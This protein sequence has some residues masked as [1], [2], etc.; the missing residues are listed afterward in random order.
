M[1]QTQIDDFLSSLSPS[2][3]ERFKN[4]HALMEAGKSKDPFLL[5]QEEME[6]LNPAI[7]FPHINTDDFVLSVP[8]RKNGF[9]WKKW[10]DREKEKDHEDLQ[11]PKPVD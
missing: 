10:F 2:E 11:R 8:T 5:T 1:T 6:T 9:I 4:L 3:I 7:S